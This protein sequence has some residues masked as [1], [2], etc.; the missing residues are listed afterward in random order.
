TI[1]EGN[2]SIF[3]QA[4]FSGNSFG[5]QRDASAAGKT[6][7]T[8][9]RV[10]SEAKAPRSIRAE[11][12]RRA[13]RRPVPKTESA[14]PPG[15][16]PRYYRPPDRNRFSGQP[17]KDFRESWDQACTRGSSRFAF[18]RSPADGRP[19][20]A[21]SWGPRECNHEDHGAPDANC[22]RAL[23]HHRPDRH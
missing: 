10:L 16:S 22:V 20:P 15:S 7:R 4:I 5:I 9:A 8:G 14:A 6:S 12:T 2:D 1:G 19:E 18:P 11:T 21:P 3:L 17:I 13:L 23:Q